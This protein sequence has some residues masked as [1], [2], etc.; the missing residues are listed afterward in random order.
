MINLKR[1]GEMETECFV[2]DM[3]MALGF[4]THLN[5]PA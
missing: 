3:Q 2:L 5:Q 1:S 4:I